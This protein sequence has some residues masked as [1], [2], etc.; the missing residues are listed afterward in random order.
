MQGFNPWSG[1]IPHAKEQ[2]SPSTT[3][4]EAL[5]LHSMINLSTP[6][7]ERPLLDGPKKARAYQ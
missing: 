3:T 2:L 5:V 1:K 4:T 7:K 6:T